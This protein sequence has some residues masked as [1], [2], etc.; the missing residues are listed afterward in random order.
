MDEKKRAAQEAARRCI[1]LLERRF[2]VKRAFVVGSL[3]GDTPWHSRSDIDIA[4][5]GLEPGKLVEALAELW[6]LIPDDV[7]L[8]LI[9]LERLPEHM[10]SGIEGGGDMDRMERLRSLV[11]GELLNLARILDRVKRTLEGL[12]GEPTDLEVA[13]LGKYV[14]DFY[15]GVERIFER[16]AVALNGGTPE[17]KRWHTDLS[18]IDHDLAVKLHRYLRFR[19][20]FRHTYGYELEWEELRPLIEGMSEVFKTLRERVEEFFK[21]LSGEGKDGSHNDR[22]EAADR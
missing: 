16:I 21:A 5:E 6:E 10:L 1:E 7:E 8:D 18:L 20:L 12:E 15:S 22:C 4:V 19:H 14:H 2:K 9:P 17:G 3:R 13:G 11:E